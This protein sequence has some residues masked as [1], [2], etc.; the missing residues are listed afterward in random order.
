VLLDRL[1]IRGKLA[2]LSVIPLLAI[3]ALTVPTVLDRADQA[4]RAGDTVREVRV[5]ARV[6]SL[7]QDLQQERLLSVGL[8]LGVVNQSVLTLQ[9]TAD[10]DRIT[11]L[12]QDLGV[13]IAGAMSRSIGQVRDLDGL[14]RS[15]LSRTVTPA[16]VMTGY[17]Q[18]ITSVLESLRLLRNV[19]TATAEG[20]QLVALDSLLTADE[21]TAATA[22]ALAIVAHDR[23][24]QALAI[25]NASRV[26]VSA[27]LGRIAAM[28]TTTQLN[29]R[30]LVDRAFTERFGAQA[31]VDPQGAVV[32]HSVE[33]IFPSIASFITLGNFVEKRIVADV[34]TAV[35]R[36]RT[37]AMATA[38]GVGSGMTLVIVVVVLL[39]FAIAATVAQPLTRLT[40]SAERIAEVAESELVRVADDESD[41]PAPVHLDSLDFGGHDEIGDLARAFTRVQGTAARLVER[42]VTSRRNIAE[43]FGH[44]GRRTNNLVSRQVA[45]IDDLEREE[46]D[47]GRLRQ[48]YRLDHLSNRLLRN[49]SSL[50]VLSGADQVDEHVAPVPFGDV[51]RLALGEI[52]GYERVDVTVSEDAALA[53]GVVTDLTLV[54]AELLENATNFSPPTTRVTLTADQFSDG[55][56]MTIIDH[57]IGMPEAR[58]AEE[59]GR[60]TRRE[61]LDLA[62][63]QVLW[64]FV[65][66]RL[67]RRHHLAVA[68]MPTVG[69]GVTVTVALGPHLLA[70]QRLPR[71]PG[72]AVAAMAGRPQL[73]PGVGLGMVRRADQLLAG[74]ESWN[75]FA[76]APRP[77]AVEPRH[78]VA[79][80]RPGPD[81]AAPVWPVPAESVTDRLS[82]SGL[83]QRIPGTH[84]PAGP[85]VP[86]NHAEP[87]AEADAAAVRE[88][89][90]QFELGVARAIDHYGASQ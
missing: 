78:L 44:I 18:V 53:P 62:P 74:A 76:V 71:V 33:L 66:G 54:I 9:V 55:V 73:P 38:Y 14:R 72:G 64:L 19:D 57:G 22:T 39:G 88:L 70:S 46:V 89:V 24:D 67:A 47:P 17:G 15:V 2:L 40:V 4:A 58:M 79:A 83:R 3:V 5:A 63:T 29:L 35:N 12:R 30:Q 25:I 90:D 65:V 26:Q 28:A 50:V 56:R 32:G 7:V 27:A 80:Q 60:L 1:R 68:L 20:R 11:D 85:P 36:R 13:D 37:A 59:N 6:G 48:L 77:R 23:S 69:G 21:A 49:A 87:P 8:L 45:L 81:R 82:R 10:A 41:A 43:M 84:H 31:T 16:Q 75:A 61:R 51:V 42:Q 52:E 86:V 34:T